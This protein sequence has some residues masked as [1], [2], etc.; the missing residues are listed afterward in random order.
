MD[1][2]LWKE[3]SF[4]NNKMFSKRNYN[5][6]FFILSKKLR[7]DLYLFVCYLIMMEYKHFKFYVKWNSRKSLSPFVYLINNRIA[8]ISFFCPINILVYWFKEHKYL[9]KKKTHFKTMNC[10]LEILFQI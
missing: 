6:R 3:N 9:E 5:E 4:L 2:K 10:F 1:K 8:S 7:T